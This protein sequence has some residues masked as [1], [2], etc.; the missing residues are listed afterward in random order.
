[1]LI[2]KPVWIIFDVND[3]FSYAHLIYLILKILTHQFKQNL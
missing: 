2:S 1:M 3:S